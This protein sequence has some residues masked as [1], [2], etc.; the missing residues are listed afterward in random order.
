MIIYRE[1]DGVF[2][3]ELL[4]PRGVGERDKGRRERKGRRTPDVL[5]GIG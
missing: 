1:V 3:W 4:S 5:F 2:G